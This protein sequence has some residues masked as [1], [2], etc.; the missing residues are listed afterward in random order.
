[1][2]GKKLDNYTLVEIVQM[3]ARDFAKRKKGKRAAAACPGDLSSNI[4]SQWLIRHSFTVFTYDKE[5]VLEWAEAYRK[6][7]PKDE[8]GLLEVHR[9]QLRD[10]KV[11]KGKFQTA[12]NARKA[13][14]TPE[15]KAKTVDLK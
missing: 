8:A 5:D 10:L 7:F 11:W 1:M 3:A 13:F 9:D 12:I 15:E 2:Q 6:Q 4:V 14:L